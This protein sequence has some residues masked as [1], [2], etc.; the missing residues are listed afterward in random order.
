MLMCSIENLFFELLCSHTL[1]IGEEYLSS[2]VI[3][4]YDH[5]HGHHGFISNHGPHAL[6]DSQLQIHQLHGIRHDNVRHLSIGKII[7]EKDYTR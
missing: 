6:H 3:L 4:A 5:F 2:G 1:T 7:R